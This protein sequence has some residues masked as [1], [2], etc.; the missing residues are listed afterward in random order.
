MGRS[1]VSLGSKGHGTLVAYSDYQEVLETAQSLLPPNCTVTL[2]ADR[3]FDHGELIRWLVKQ[4]WHWAIR[5]KCDLNV[6]RA[7]GFR[8]KIGDLVAPKE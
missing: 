4:E 1:L 5:A 6:Q 3:G 7:N 2:L 8:A